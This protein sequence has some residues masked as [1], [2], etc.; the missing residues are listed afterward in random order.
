[1]DQTT[2]TA[3]ANHDGATYVV[4]LDGVADA[5]GTVPL[6]VGENVITIEITA[7][8]GETARTYTV[9]VN[10]AAPPPSTDATLSGLELSGVALAFDPATDSYA[11]SVAHD[12]EQTTVTATPNHD[13]AD[14][15]RP[16]WTA[17][18]TRTGPWTWPWARTSSASS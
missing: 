3:T 18:P 7:E 4:K 13:G 1:M 2:V 8:D 10:R 17:W 5:D 16:S 14:L 15:R 12:V 11:A 6:T 9:S